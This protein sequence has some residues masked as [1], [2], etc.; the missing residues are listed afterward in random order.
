MKGYGYSIWLVPLNH[1]AIKKMYGMVHI[2]HV[3]V[4]TN[5]CSAPELKLP[6]GEFRLNSFTSL[7]ELKSQYKHDPLCAWGWECQSPDV[8]IKHTPHMSCTYSQPPSGITEPPGD[9]LAT[10]H[11]VDTT[12]T[13]PSEWTLVNMG[14]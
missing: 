4:Q 13:D 1:V 5:L 14:K 6:K 11:L 7:V 9:L 3:T 10:M 2:P 8:A 12:S